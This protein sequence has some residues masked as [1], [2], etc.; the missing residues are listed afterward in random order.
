MLEY[1]CVYGHVN[2][3]MNVHVCAYSHVCAR[4]SVYVCV[5]VHVY[6]YIFMHVCIH[7]CFVCVFLHA[8]IK[9]KPVFIRRVFTSVYRNRSRMSSSML[10]HHPGT[11]SSTHER[12]DTRKHKK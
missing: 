8:H 7:V 3:C 9:T 11:S 12:N 6:M 5:S 10:Q 4:V 2:L 1:M